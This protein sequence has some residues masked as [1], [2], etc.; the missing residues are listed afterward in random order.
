MRLKS[1]KLAGFKS[2]V[3]PTTV[4]LPSN[5]CA[6]VGPNGCGKSNVIDAVRWVLGESSAKTLRGE[7]MTDVIF[8]G[9]TGRQPVSQASIELI[10]DNSRGKITGEFGAYNEISV[11][12]VVSR[13][14]QSDYYLNATKCRR[15]D[16][17][18][19]F[20]GTGLG[21]RSYAIIEQGVVS[22]LIESKPEDLRIFIEE[23]A[24]ISKYKDRRRETG[25][26]MQRT[27][28]NLERLSDLREE[29]DRN[30]LHLSRQADAAKKYSKF[31]EE[32]RLRQADL[33]AIQMRELNLSRAEIDKE[34]LSSEV[35]LEAANADAQNVAMQMEEVREE[36]LAAAESFNS[37]QEEFYRL[38]GEVAQAEQAIRYAKERRVELLQDL[39][40]TQASIRQIQT[41]L[42]SDQRRLE[43]WRGEIKDSE[44]TL[45]SKKLEYEEAKS[46]LTVL[47]ESIRIASDG[48]DQFNERA[49]LP[50]QSAE[51]NRSLIEQ[52]EEGQTRFKKQ[53]EKLEIEIK[54]L[55]LDDPID[56]EGDATT[57][58][59]FADQAILDIEENRRSL[60]RS[61]KDVDV[62]I[63]NERRQ[64]D[65][66][67]IK[68]QE[69]RGEIAS[70]VALQESAS[71]H[72]EQ[73]ALKDWV[74][75]RCLES[76]GSVYAA[77]QVESGWESAVEQVLGD[78]LAA[79]FLERGSVAAL[80][81]LAQLPGGAYLVD[82]L[83][84]APPALE[85]T[86]A[87]RVKGP[88]RILQWLSRVRTAETIA[89]AIKIQQDLGPNESIVVSD[90]H[91]MGNGWHRRRSVGDSSTGMIQRQTQLGECR[92]RLDNIIE[93]ADGIERRISD[94]LEDRSRCDNEVSINQKALQSAVS[95]RAELIAEQRAAQERAEQLEQRRDRLKSDRSN[96][97]ISF[98]RAQEKITESREKFA[99]AMDK[100]EVDQRERLDLQNQR[101]LI[102]SRARQQRGIVG[103]LGDALVREDARIKGLEAQL[104]SVTEG[105]ERMNGQLSDFELR[106]ADLAAALPDDDD[107]EA[108]LKNT[109][110]VLLEQRLRAETYLSSQRNRLNDSE[111]SM[112]KLVDKRNRG[113]QL[114]QTIRSKLESLRLKAAESTVRVEG[115]ANEMMKLNVK[116][117]E[118]IARLG[119]KANIKNLQEELDQIARRIHRL[120]P[121][122]LAA[123]EEHTIASERKKYLDSQNSDLESALATLQSA[124]R[125]IDSETRQRFKDTFE[126]I[127][128][129]FADLFPKLFG[130]G[131][132]SLEMTGHDLLDT[133]V[134]IFARPPGK[135]N[136]TIH[137]LSGGEK[138][139]TAI[140]LVFAIFQLN[141][142]PFCMLDEVDAPLDDANVGR[143]A[144]MVKEMSEKVQ[145]VFITHNKITMEAAEQLMGVTM[146][147]PG[148]SRLVS[149]DMGEAEQMAA[150]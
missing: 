66:V 71:D 135:K 150:I 6:V 19:L 111:D 132:A 1:I 2:F 67:R 14:S 31:K 116:P 105:V 90:G 146:N 145:F 113:D 22:R 104:I 101:T 118:A 53:I 125:K 50:I 21:P 25:N 79:S 134:A 123:V 61:L 89:E 4:H 60:Q 10:F 136:S 48:W 17:T 45:T 9:T 30:L 35:D 76:M 100:I 133:G 80:D 112:R 33:S 102:N 59:H 24:G 122:N 46:E 18:D 107:S 57:L 32:E 13:D 15:R 98:E 110:N 62:A 52:L 147:E 47:E 96:L 40:Q 140:A 42:S 56:P 29:I 99:L 12:R 109:L 138:A 3:D 58:I 75:F 92:Q 44:P 141:P 5:M 51:V 70:L 65:M 121:I 38:G 81:N 43:K 85:G 106:A 8:N 23:A 36:Q 97:T 55:A 139:M 27:R 83:T 16:I 103:K 49:R 26:R 69:M 120:G 127:N 74:E 54:S 144:R 142:A 126:Q 63:E 130:G 20:L 124:M 137:L 91:W 117:D 82:N 143:Y 86:L 72:D 108:K 34:T 37:S 64:Q 88:P 77:I 87:A 11:R 28:E 84:T 119:E 7:S 114:T 73:E 115:L 93:E 129:G 128:V 149:V 148:V 39:E 94:L 95:E 78:A 41:H 68:A 131:T